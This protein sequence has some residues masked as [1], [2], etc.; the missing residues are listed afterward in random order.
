MPDH[1][2]YDLLLTTLPVCRGLGGH[3]EHRDGQTTTK[4]LKCNYYLSLK[5]APVLGLLSSYLLLCFI[6]SFHYV[7][8]FKQAGRAGGDK[9]RGRF[10]HNSHACLL[11][12][13]SAGHPTAA[14]LWGTP[15]LGLEVMRVVVSVLGVHLW[16]IQAFCPCSWNRYLRGRELD[17]RLCA[18]GRASSGTTIPDS[19][20]D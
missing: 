5:E 20:D 2:C 13:P 6:N 3:Q 19:P 11:P 9:G 1:H 12:T 10:N 4:E 14:R 18:P 8:N 7:T 15:Y 17:D 16:L